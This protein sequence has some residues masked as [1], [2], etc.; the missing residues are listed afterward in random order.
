MYLWPWF[1]DVC[2][3]WIFSLPESDFETK[4]ISLT[5]TAGLESDPPKKVL[6]STLTRDDSREE[7]SEGFLLRL[8][9]DQA[10]L[11]PRDFGR[12]RVEE[13]LVL[14]SILD[15]GGNPIAIVDD[16]AMGLCVCCSDVEEEERTVALGLTADQLTGLV[17]GI[18][19]LI[20]L[21]AAFIVLVCTCVII[22]RRRR[23]V[24]SQQG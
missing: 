18:V 9:I 7:P 14:V 19:V 10:G 22:A 3:S 11:D 16:I 24:G 2:D 15:D 20:I 6:G 1:I 4:V 13:N 17:A 21:L 5:F 23:K 8:V 12:V